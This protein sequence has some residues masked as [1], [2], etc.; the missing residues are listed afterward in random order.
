MRP[1]ASHLS[2]QTAS[3]RAAPRRASLRAILLATSALASA[4]LPITVAHAG[5]A[6]WNPGAVAPANADFNNGDNWAGTPDKSVPTLLGTA[7]FNAGNPPMSRSRG[8][9]LSA[10]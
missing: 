7:T 1:Q 9:P 5:D 8:Q 6:T 10:E 4:A 3:R 2:H